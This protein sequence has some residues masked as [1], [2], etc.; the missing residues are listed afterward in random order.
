MKK[1]KFYS[2]EEIE[3]LKNISSELSVNDRKKALHA[4]AKRNSRVYSSAYGK[5]LFLSKSKNLNLNTSAKIT[6]KTIVIPIKSIK[7]ENNFIII[8]Y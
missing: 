3:Q 1:I 7:I 6:D 2:K 8:S 4:F 5:W